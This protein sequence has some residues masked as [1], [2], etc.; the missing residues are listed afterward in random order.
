[1]TI[2]AYSEQEEVA[3][4]IDE[5]KIYQDLEKSQALPKKH[6]HNIIKKARDTNGLTPL[7]V[8]ALLQ[9]KDKD[10]LDLIFA[11]L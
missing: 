1:M 2:Q 10:L 11:A 9:T 5:G 3:D 8:A 7:E 6:V 4:F